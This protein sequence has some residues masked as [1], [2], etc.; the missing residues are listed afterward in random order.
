[1]SR[2]LLEEIFQKFPNRQREDLIPLLHE[3]H[4]EN[5]FLSVEI[6]SRVSQYLSI[7]VNKIYGVATFY[8]NFRF[9]PPGRY[10]IR[11]CNGTACKVAGA[12]P[13]IQELE[14]RLKSSFEKHDGHGMFS[15]EIVSCLGACGLA[16]IIEI[17]GEFYTGMTVAKLQLLLN[18][19]QTK[20][21][22]S[23]ET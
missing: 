19:L 18:H 22:A 3:L 5:G 15:M 7:S 17:N 4:D 14:K 6:I 11:L 21:Q 8:D 2:N 12:A 20:E 13:L 23:H 9:T 1:M 10:H 16:P